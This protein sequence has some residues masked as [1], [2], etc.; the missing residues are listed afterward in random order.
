MSAAF[1]RAARLIDLITMFAFFINLH[2]PMRDFLRS[3]QITISCNLTISTSKRT[4]SEQFTMT[5]AVKRS[6]IKQIHNEMHP[7]SQDELIIFSLS[8]AR[9][10][11]FV[12]VATA[13]LSNTIN[14][15]QHWTRFSTVCWIIHVVRQLASNRERPER[16]TKMISLFNYM[17]QV[18][19]HVRH[20]KINTTTENYQSTK[21]N[22]SLA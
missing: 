21:K 13:R 8:L 3:P 2:Q 5:R 22:A 12:G 7:A 17:A 19:H 1:Y 6:I 18:I 9:P 20:I 4:C 15:Y 16:T 14:K 10:Q 11:R